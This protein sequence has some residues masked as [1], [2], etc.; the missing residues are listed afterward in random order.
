[1]FDLEQAIAEWRRQM[2]AEGLKTLEVLDELESHLRVEIEQQMKAGT[3]SE[4]AFH[5]AVQ[6]VGQ[7]HTLKNEFAK[8]GKMKGND[9]I[10]HNRLYCA[11]LTICA[12]VNGMT[13]IGLLYWQKTVGWSLGHLP[14][15]SLP[16]MTAINFAYTVAIVA[17]LMARRYRPETGRHLTRF[18]NWALLPALV[19][20]TVLGLYGMWKVDKEKTQYV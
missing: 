12:V 7:A 4:N 2:L 1:M 16:W 9:L 18:L 20:G 13:T 3:N 14:A 15:R 8:A 11:V 5:S 17:T 6:K 10:N 19:A